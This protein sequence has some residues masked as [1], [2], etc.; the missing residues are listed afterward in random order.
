MSNKDIIRFLE[1]IG[2]LLEIKGENPFKSRAYY[3]AARIIET[4]DPDLEYLVEK[5][6]LSSI[7]GIGKALEQKITELITTGK[8]EYYEKLKASVPP[9]LIE[10]LRIQH[11]G[12]KKIN[13]LYGKLEI[14]TMGELE[15]A[16]LENRLVE[17]PG[18][19]EKTQTKILAGINLIKK[20]NERHLYAEM[21]EDA[22]AVL[23]AIRKYKSVIRLSIAGSL[24]R[25]NETVKDIDI[26]A[27]T[28]DS[29]KLSD[30]FVT[31]PQIDTIIAKGKTKVSVTLKSGINSD[32]R[33]VTDEQFPYALHHFTGSKEHNVAMRGRAKSMGIK[34][35]EYGLFGTKGL[36]PCKSEEEIFST[37]GLTYIPPELREN[38]GEIETAEKGEMPDLI[39]ESDVRGLLHVHT[40]ASDG[41]DSLEEIV[42]AAKNLGFE[43]I[44]ISDHS[45]SAYYAGGLSIEDIQR[46]HK[47]IDA[48][49]ARERK[50]HIFKGIEADIL[51]DGSLDYPDDILST[52]DFVIG[53]IH[54]NFSL[55]EDEMN[56]R[57]MKALDNPYVTMLA[58][59]T[60]RLLLAREPYPVDIKK[61]I[62][63]ASMRNKIIELNA[64]PHRL[65]IDWRSC[66]Y[67][68][69]K[70]VKIAINPD[71]HNVEGL[72]HFKFGIN[73]ARKGWITSSDCINCLEREDIET[74]LFQKH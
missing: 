57:I 50:F 70:N 4:I 28:D 30:H 18:F 54:S 43:Y 44:G 59:P 5:G 19:G 29:L 52:F 10:M 48:I 72:R 73:I 61:I 68:K 12:P 40:N 33:I 55:A 21:I 6:T 9:G 7:K 8:L 26:V 71:A 17:L 60:G 49:N 16:C 47:E 31:L 36:M 38:T 35:N 34:I 23:E 1:E 22:E 11:L 51:T 24:R 64:N 45:R 32:L 69:K 13:A 63:Y 3:T 20:Y 41:S 46:Q 67:A 27:S 58:H 62:E 42:S 2:K 56:Q 53:A 15:Y 65:D 25:L 14:S 66:L 74:L 39:K 37:L